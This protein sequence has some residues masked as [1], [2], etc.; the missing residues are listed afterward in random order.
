[1]KLNLILILLFSVLVMLS[2]TEH[3]EKE[4]KPP[5]DLISYDTMVDIMVDFRLMDAALVYE[6]RS[7]SPKLS[8][9]KY[10]LH[11]SILQKYQITREQ[12]TSSF[13]YYQQDLNVM[14]KMF[15]DAI[16]KLSKMKS[17]IE[18]EE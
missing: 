7:G 12:F 18:R 11:N 16:T 3:L 14:D 10:Y 1:M 5:S 4:I 6:Q 13:D 9:I 2:C 8:D 15:A 17:E